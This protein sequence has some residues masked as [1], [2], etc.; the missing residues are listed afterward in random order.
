MAKQPSKNMRTIKLTP[1]EASHILFA[2]DRL[3]EDG[4]YWGP[5]EQCLERR[6]RIV[7]KLHDAF[8]WD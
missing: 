7:D 8:D 2:L 1:V 3:H 5:R 4:A 6:R